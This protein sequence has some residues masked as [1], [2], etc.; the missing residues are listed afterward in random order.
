MNIG[1]ALGRKTMELSV[2]CCTG[3]WVRPRNRIWGHLLDAVLLVIG[4]GVA[5]VV[6]VKAKHSGVL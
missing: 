5:E 1:S 4:A 6:G 3:P 2:Q